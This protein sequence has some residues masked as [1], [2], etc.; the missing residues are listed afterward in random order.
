M[1]ACTAPALGKYDR[2]IQEYESYLDSLM[3]Q[4]MLLQGIENYSNFRLDFGDFIETNHLVA[5]EIERVRMKIR[6]MKAFP[7]MD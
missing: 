3:H 6:E 4:Q 2:R 7:Q 1:R 5:V